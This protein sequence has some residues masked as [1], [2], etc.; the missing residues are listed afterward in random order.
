MAVDAPK[1]FKNLFEDRRSIKSES[2]Y[3]TFEQPWWANDM[4]ILVFALFS[5]VLIVIDMETS[6]RKDNPT[7]WW[8]LALIDLA[9][10]AKAIG[11]H[12]FSSRK[13]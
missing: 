6:L 3:S 7:L 8:T 1:W 13:E 10:R 12:T 2:K 9:R 11:T 5:V 4:L